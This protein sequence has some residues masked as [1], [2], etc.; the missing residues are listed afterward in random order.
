M[1][2]WSLGIHWS[3]TKPRSKRPTLWCQ[4][5]ANTGPRILVFQADRMAHHDARIE[6]CSKQ[7]QG[8][9]CG[10][11]SA[12][13]CPFAVA[14]AIGVVLVHPETAVLSRH[15]CGQLTKQLFV[16][17][18]N[19]PKRDASPCF[20]SD[21]RARSPKSKPA[22][23]LSGPSGSSCPPASVTSSAALSWCIAWSPHRSPR[24]R[25]A[26]Q[27]SLACKPNCPRRWRLPWC[28][29]PR[30]H[31]AASRAEHCTICAAHCRLGEYLVTFRF[32]VPRLTNGSSLCK[33]A[34]FQ[35]RHTCSDVRLTHRR[36]QAFTLA[37]GTTTTDNHSTDGWTTTVLVKKGNET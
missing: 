10:C 24:R 2:A 33:R 12:N 32:N 22:D 29:I 35:P 20:P 16:C 25:S 30:L 28:M 21:S 27:A 14:A 6:L 1:E 18:D 19:L 17:P 9:A 3:S 13:S 7:C 31:R 36:I 26:R 4:A 5:P 15:A 8:F 34:T 37:H 11:L 23:H